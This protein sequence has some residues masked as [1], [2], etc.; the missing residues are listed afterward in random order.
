[1]SEENTPVDPMDVDLDTF[2]ADFFGQ[3]SAESEQASSETDETDEN[4]HDAN[5]EDTQ[6]DDDTVETDVE[7]D[8]SEDEEVD[9]APPPEQKKKSRFQERI[10]ELTAKAREA[11]RQ[12]NE[13]KTRLDSPKQ[14]AKTAPAPQATQD[15]TAPDPNELREDGT[16]VYQ[17]GEFDPQYIRDLTKHTFEAE[18]RSR[19]TQEQQSAEQA[20]MQRQ[21]DA[22]QTEWNSKLEPARERYPDFMD[23]SSELISSLSDVPPA[24]GE[25]LTATLMSMDHGPDVLYYLA[26][27][28]AEARKIVDAG[29]AK[30]TVM[31]GRIEARFLD[32]GEAKKQVRVSRA[33]E[34]PTRTNKGTAV[35]K[36]KVQADTDDLDAF[37]SEFFKK[38][39]K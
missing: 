38:R 20:E 7:D 19:Q 39:R 34:P 3:K 23:K 2:S 36:P 27:N 5:E 11:E 17:L 16:P 15:D 21:K 26:Q 12:L 22:L 25:Y 6:S 24:Y 18:F 31:L 30:A 32:E 8:E 29:A 37:S 28:P 4:G 14:D 9:E 35:I 10:D 1:M 33:P 13:L